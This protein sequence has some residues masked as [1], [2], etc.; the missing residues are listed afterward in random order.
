[1]GTAAASSAS[2][3]ASQ[4]SSGRGYLVDHNGQIRFH[5]LG[6]LDVAGL[7][8]AQ[9]QQKLEEGLKPFIKNP[10]VT[11]RYT[12]SRVTVLGDVAKP[13]VIEMPDQKL[14]VLDAIGLAGDLTPFA[15]RDKVF[16]IREKDG[17]RT[18][19]ELNVG[20]VDVYKSP[21]F[22][23]EQNDLVYVEPTRRKPTG[24]EQVLMRNITIGTSLLSIVTLIITLA[25]N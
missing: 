24:N 21:F 11:I 14:S 22:Y 7:T 6:L 2:S 19:G 4:S 1:M 16:V 12:N 5:E 20:N 10:Y 13:G 18:V 9:L 15:R 8:K 3:G 17:K 25:T 23:L